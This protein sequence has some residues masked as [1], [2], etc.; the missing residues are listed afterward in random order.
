MAKSP[1]GGAVPLVEAQWS[2]RA[3]VDAVEPAYALVKLTTARQLLKRGETADSYFSPETEVITT[4]TVED[5]KLNLISWEHELEIVEDFQPTYHIPAD[6]STYQDQDPADRQANVEACLEGTLWMA[7]RVR[8]RDLDTTIIPL[9]K[10][11]TSEEWA[12]C[13]AVF[14][15]CAFEFPMVAVFATQYFTGGAGIRINEL[16]E[17]VREIATK[18]HRAIML[19]GLLSPNYLQRMPA[20]VCAGTGLNQWRQPINPRKQTDEEMRTIWEQVS[21]EVDEALS[22]SGA[23]ED[24]DPAMHAEQEVA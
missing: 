11:C 6:Y 2:H 10:G 1:P 22:Q 18:Q 17:D 20:T 23:T 7:R 24:A 19:I 16:V 15:R 14:D 5:T 8:E 21:D 9:V 4:S 3:F 12:I 13:Y